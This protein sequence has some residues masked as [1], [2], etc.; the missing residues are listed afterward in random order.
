M[1]HVKKNFSKKR[2][3]GPDVIRGIAAICVVFFHVLYISGIPYSNVNLWITGRFDFFVRVFFMISAFSMMYVY[4]E[5]L[6]S[7]E[8][9]RKFYFKRFVRIAPL[10]YFIML[11]TIL[12]TY[13]QSG[14]IQSI[15]E[16][17][18][19]ATFVFALI[20]GMH[21]SIVGGGWS[22]GVEMIFYLFFPFFMIISRNIKT[23]SISLIILLAISIMIKPYYASYLS[24]PIKNFGLLNILAHLQ[25]FMVGILAFHIWKVTPR[26]IINK[27]FNGVLLLLSMTLVIVFFRCQDIIPEEIFLSIFGFIIVLSSSLGLPN[28]IDNKITRWL[29]KISYSTYLVQFPVISILL[30]TGGYDMIMTI[31]PSYIDANL[32]ASMVTIILVIMLSS[33]TYKYIE[34]PFRNL[35][36]HSELNQQWEGLSLDKTDKTSLSD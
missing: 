13:L 30:Y 25:Y 20:P 4:H 18:T 33:L 8:E 16:I 36:G 14:N 19:S 6:S 15:S 17:I 12:I 31:C 3:H 7:Q 29:G 10:F 9:M 32:L 22:I 2:I 27:T 35:R 24:E 34:N 26:A 21:N 28:A 5:R 1:L 23:T 11:I